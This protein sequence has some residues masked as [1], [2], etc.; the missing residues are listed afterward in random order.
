MYRFTTPRPPLTALIL[1]TITLLI[2]C[3]P[4]LAWVD[5]TTGTAHASRVTRP[6]DIPEKNWQPG[7][8]GVDLAARPGDPVLAAGGGTVHYVGTIA[9]TPVVSIAHADGIRTTYQPVRTELRKGDPVGEGD[10]IGA[11]A[12]SPA[13]APNRHDGLHWGAIVGKE[14]Y[15]DPLSLLSAPLIRLKPVR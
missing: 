13:N 8:R 3:P 11:L 10:I 6:A 4:A 14:R 7:H 15:I 1:A 9:G 5:P 2:S 12:Y